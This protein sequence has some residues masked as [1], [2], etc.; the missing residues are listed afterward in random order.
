MKK[1]VLCLVLCVQF[2]CS[3]A[4]FAQTAVIK[5]LSGTV[6]LKQAGQTDFVPAKV[7]DEVAQ[8][9]IVSTG[10][11]STALIEAGSSVIT[12]RPLTRLSLAEISSAS[13]TETINVSLQT[14]RVRVDVNPPLGTRTTMSVRGPNATASVRGTSFEFDTRNLTVESGVVAFQGSRGAV[15]LVGA[16]SSSVINNDGKVTDPIETNDFSQVSPP[17][18]AETPATDSSVNV[19]F[20]LTFN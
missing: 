10:F 7:G 19:T 1:T 13:G 5:E 12:V 4:V 8:S 14:G 6:E 15:M 9:T 18:A 16:G 2:L 11:K 20:T 17:A 3:A